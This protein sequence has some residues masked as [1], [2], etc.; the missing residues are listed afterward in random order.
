MRTVVTSL[1]AGALVACG[2]SSGSQDVFPTGRIL[3]STF[4]PADGSALP[5]APSACTLMGQ[6]ANVAGLALGFSSIGGLCGRAANLCIQKKASEELVS[7][8]IVKVGAF[9]QPAVGT[10]TY[11][12]TST[13]TPDVTGS[14]SFVIGSIEK[15]DAQCN[16]QS[17]GQS[18]ASGTITIS[19]ID[20][21]RVRGNVNAV[22]S[23]GNTFG[24]TF[25]VPLCTS[26]TLEACTVAT[27][28]TVSAAACQP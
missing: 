12:I 17:A 13:P 7:F 28:C 2:S 5:L 24:G 20:S 8:T 15:L 21:N 16:D 11:P 18:I 19:F 23:D 14:V 9:A 27:G 25:D 22:L 4:S 26:V 10:G 3:G 6:Q 1:L